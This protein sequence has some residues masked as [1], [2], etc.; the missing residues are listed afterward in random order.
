MGA[1]RARD[2]DGR[3]VGP[4]RVQ[5][6]TL[7][8]GKH[9][10]AG[11]IILATAVKIGLM[12]AIALCWREA[13]RAI[14]GAGAQKSHVAGLAD[15]ANISDVGYHLGTRQERTVQSADSQGT[16]PSAQWPL[17]ESN[18]CKQFRRGA[19][20]TTY[21]VL[22]ALQFNCSPRDRS[23]NLLALTDESFRA[24]LTVGYFHLANNL[25]RALCT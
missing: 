13:N 11:W 5:P 1:L 3:G 2:G 12:L 23:N 25:K 14:S 6:E 7:L 21:A 10:F 8:L 24:I 16:K 19:L 18:K 9:H 17:V 15:L 22:G 20:N 4:S